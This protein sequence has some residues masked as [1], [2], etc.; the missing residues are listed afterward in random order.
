MTEES[1]ISA[2]VNL[3]EDGDTKKVV[4]KHQQREYILSFADNVIKMQT[5]Q[6]QA[7]EAVLQMPKAAP[8]GQQTTTISNLGESSQEEI[9]VANIAHSEESD[10]NMADASSDE[11]DEPKK[12]SES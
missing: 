7:E 3:R 11:E 5:G 2:D 6:T 10:D 12:K 4:P 8:G 1:L 9:S